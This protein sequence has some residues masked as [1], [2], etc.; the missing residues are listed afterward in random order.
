MFFSIRPHFFLLCT[1]SSAHI[2]FYE[3]LH[4]SRCLLKKFIFFDKKC[5]FIERKEAT[6]KFYNSFFINNVVEF[7]EKRKKNCNQF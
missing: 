5:G 2:S 6:V 4:F 1:S 3:E 7:E